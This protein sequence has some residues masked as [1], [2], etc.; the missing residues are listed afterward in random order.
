[1]RTHR[2]YCT[3]VHVHV[4]Q[5]AC[6]MCCYSCVR[7]EA[8]QYATGQLRECQTLWF[9]HQR[10][11]GWLPRSHKK[12]WLCWIHGCKTSPPSLSH[13]LSL[14]LSFTLSLSLFPHSL[15]RH[16]L[17]LIAWAYQ[18]SA[19]PEGLWCPCWHLESRYL[20]GWASQR[21]LTL[22]GTEVQQWVSAF[23][24]HRECTTPSSW[25]GTLLSTFLRF[26]FKMVGASLP[27][28]IHDRNYTHPLLS[29]THYYISPPLSPS[30]SPPFPLSLSLPLP[31]VFPRR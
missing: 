5:H 3:C 27:T 1:M 2:V 4:S 24:T 19:Y 30:L 17:S 16:S 28:Y 8:V 26:Y 14:S 21:R 29:L 15:I 9:W 18:P 6:T 7:C 20:P 25:Q 10:S 13:L 22:H 12:R 11:A 23:N 31:S